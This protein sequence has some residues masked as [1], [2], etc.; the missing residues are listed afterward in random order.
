[1]LPRLV[2]IEDRPDDWTV[3]LYALLR[4]RGYAIAS[5]SKLNVVL[6]RGNAAVS[7]YDSSA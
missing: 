3:D 2:L 4:E 7:A 6:E 5:R 1:M